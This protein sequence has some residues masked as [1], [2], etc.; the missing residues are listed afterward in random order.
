[1]NENFKPIFEVGKCLQQEELL[2]YLDGK[3]SEESNAAIERHLSGCKL[4][5]DALEGLNLVENR[6]FIPMKVK[7]LKNYIKK[8]IPSGKKRRKPLKLFLLLSISVLILL[9][10]IL[11]VFWFF[12]FHFHLK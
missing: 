7:E 8:N 9:I 12:H 10:F 4:C 3:L 5:N 11:V 1:M 6:K 2:L